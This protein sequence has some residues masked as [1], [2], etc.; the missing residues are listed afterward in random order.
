MKTV[1]TY[2]CISH[3]KK[4]PKHFIFL[5]F[6]KKLKTKGEWGLQLLIIQLQKIEHDL[7]KPCN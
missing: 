6:V 7:L 4:A 5:K 2:G 1:F 3:I